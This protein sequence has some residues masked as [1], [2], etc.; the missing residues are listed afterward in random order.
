MRLLALVPWQTLLDAIGW[1]LA[2]IYDFVP[3]YGLSIIILTL[4]TRFVLLPLGIK[5]IRSMQSMQAIQPKVKAVQQKYKGNRTKQNEEVMK[6]YQEHGVNPLSGCWPM[7]LQL[8]ILVTFYSVLRYPQSPPHLPA[9]SEL[10]QTIDREIAPGS[11]PDQGGIQFLG[12]NLMCSA[13]QAGHP[14][15][16]LKTRSG[17]QVGDINCGHG[18]PVRIPY[19]IFAAAMVATTFYQQRQM[20]KASPPGASQQQQM[21]TR[22]MPLMF[23]FWGF[24]FPAALVLYWTTSNLI[25]IGQQRLLLKAAHLEDGTPA[26]PA[27]KSSKPGRRGL[28]ASMMERAEEQRKQRDKGPSGRPGTGSKKPAPGRK[29]SPEDEPAAG[30]S[31]PK[32]AGNSQPKQQSDG[33]AKPGGARPSGKGSGSGGNGAGDR[34]KRRKR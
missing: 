25:Q 11:N 7:L 26:L 17:E 34:K 4:L 18:I 33:T 13:Q 2:K 12:V 1:L 3:N 6:I 16:E 31:E 23:G 32:Q 14:V 29:E 22:I 9:G 15:S 21:L 30:N 5:Q 24:F 10:R 28:F 8:P 20:Q 19:Y 27:P